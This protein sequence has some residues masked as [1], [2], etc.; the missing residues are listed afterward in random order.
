MSTDEKSPELNLAASDDVVIPVLEEEVVTGVKAVETGAVR[1]D[2]H[3]D[4]RV[5]KVEMPLLHEDVEIKRVPVNRVVDQA[6]PVRTSGD[7]VIISVVEEEMIVTKRLV[8]KEEIYLIKHR[9]KDRFEREVELETERAEVHRLDAQGRVVDTPPTTK[10]APAPSPAPQ[11]AV[12]RR[13]LL[14]GAP[15]EKIIKPR[16]RH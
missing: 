1:V 11:P 5:R 13:S 15:T 14:G 8:L 12:R 9:T 7:T 2:K 6:P 4:K 16:G 3:V 10:P